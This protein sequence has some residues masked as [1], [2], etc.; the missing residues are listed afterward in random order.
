MEVW[1]KR[2]REAFF[3]VM[4]TIAVV[5]FFC[6]FTLMLLGS[7]LLARWGGFLIM[8][9]GIVLLIWLSRR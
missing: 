7:M 3:W 1:L 2:A 5:T 9:G 4:T 6:V 8:I